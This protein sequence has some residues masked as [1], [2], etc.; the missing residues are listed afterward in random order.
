M[1]PTFAFTWGWSTEIPQMEG[2][3][4]RVLWVDIAAGQ[5]TYLGQTMDIGE[6]RGMAWYQV[7]RDAVSAHELQAI[8]D[9]LERT[10]HTMLFQQAANAACTLMAFTSPRR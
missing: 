10:A 5:M 9:L 7:N 8:E 1:A 3:D 2:R 6:W 4:C